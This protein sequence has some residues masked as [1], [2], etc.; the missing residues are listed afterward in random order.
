VLVGSPYFLTIGAFTIKPSVREVIG[1]G[2]QP[3]AATEAPGADGA[4]L[5]PRP[6]AVVLDLDSSLPRRLAQ[7][8]WGL[9]TELVNAFHYVAWVPGLLGVWWFRRRVW[10]M[11][12]TV[13]VAVFCALHAL[14]LWRLAVVVGYLSD[15]HVQ[16][17]VLC[18]VFPAVAFVWEFPA[19]VFAWVRGTGASAVVR[20]CGAAAL[21]A[22]ALLLALTAVGMPKTLQTL[23]AKRAGYHA[24]GLWLAQYA[25]ASDVIMDKHMWAHYYSGRV[26]LENKEIPVPPDHKPVVYH[27]VGKTKDRDADPTLP[28]TF[29]TEEQ[30]RARG[31]TP[32]YWWPSGG[33]LER[34]KVIVYMMPP[35]S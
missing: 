21:V 8:M 27:V 9:G 29:P 22:A 26:F 14:V 11:P 7:G 24:A 31:G 6:A 28:R 18:G 3:L 23:H 5:L 10:K 30:V 13:V 1:L 34:A 12:G 20:P 32:R 19:V 17:L 35:G 25:D 2:N 16:V 4:G 15:R 33:N